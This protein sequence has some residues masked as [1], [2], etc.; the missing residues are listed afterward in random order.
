[1]YLAKRIRII[2]K[3]ILEITKLSKFDKRYD[4]EIIDCNK[5]GI[6]VK[7]ELEA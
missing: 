4:I 7:V 1:M 3:Q 6:T 5:T 2:K